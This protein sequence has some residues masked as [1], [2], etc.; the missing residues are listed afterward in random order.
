MESS[1]SSA[2]R[3]TCS[4]VPPITD[5]PRRQSEGNNNGIVRCFGWLKVEVENSFDFILLVTAEDCGDALDPVRN[6]V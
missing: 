5:S 6:K 4:G 3:E 1:T 2:Y